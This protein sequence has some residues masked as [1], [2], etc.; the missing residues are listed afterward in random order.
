[1]FNFNAQLLG[2]YLR[3]K[4]VSSFIASPFYVSEYIKAWKEKCIKYEP[5]ILKDFLIIFSFK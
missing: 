4:K 1:M 2:C 5:M 3:K